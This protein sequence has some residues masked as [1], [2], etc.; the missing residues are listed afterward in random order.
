MDLEEFRFNLPK[1]ETLSHAFPSH[2]RHVFKDSCH[3]RIE[4]QMTRSVCGTFGGN[5]GPFCLRWPVETF[6]LCP[7]FIIYVH[8]SIVICCQGNPVHQ[9]FRLTCT[10]GGKAHFHCCRQ[11]SVCTHVLVQHTHANLP[12]KCTPPTTAARLL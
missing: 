3:Q 11:D 8:T 7:L 10:Q 4:H 5:K 9:T 1:V 6:F 12:Q 2:S